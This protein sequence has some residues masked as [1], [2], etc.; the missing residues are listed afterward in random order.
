[1]SETN[2]EN[3]KF[4]RDGN[5]YIIV[6]EDPSEEFAKAINDT[7]FSHLAVKATTVK[8]VT[9]EKKKIEPPPVLDEKN[10]MFNRDDRILDVANPGDYRPQAGKYAGM[11]LEE[12]K[13]EYGP[14][15]GIDFYTQVSGMIRGNTQRKIIIRAL[16]V[17]REDLLERDADNDSMAKI[18]EFF[19]A[20]NP[21]LREAVEVLTNKAGIGGYDRF[22]EFIQKSDEQ[23]IRDAY[24]SLVAYALKKFKTV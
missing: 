8:D 13:T 19:D 9:P 14:I 4:Y 1:M 16:R 21:S 6:I 15:V 17:I 5:R 20:Y 7:I 12:A 22:E 3:V 2:V 11:T 18:I 10:R 24:S 23:I